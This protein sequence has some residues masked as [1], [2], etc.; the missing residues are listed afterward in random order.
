MKVMTI[1]DHE[2]ELIEAVLSTVPESRVK[3]RQAIAENRSMYDYRTKVDP[4]P[5]KLSSNAKIG[6]KVLNK[7]WKNMPIYTLTLEE[8]ATCPKTC[9]HFADCYGNNMAQ[10]A[11]VLHGKDFEKTLVEQ[12]AALAS[13]HKNGFVVRLHVLGDFYSVDY[14]NLWAEMLQKHSN[15]YIY[16]YTHWHP[17][18]PI[19][20]AIFNLW[21]ANKKRFII[22]FSDYIGAQ[23]VLRAN[24][25]TMVD[26]TQGRMF[27]CPNL[28]SKKGV[29]NGR[30]YPKHIAKDDR[31]NYEFSLS[32]GECTLCWE[33]NKTVIFPT[34]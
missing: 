28:Q 19:G 27:V 25:E 16:G 10:T 1:T 2:L 17:G 23:N 18:T 34:H 13:K 31:D 20:D 21:L 30:N 22:R 7:T 12:L 26:Q 32:C 29:R 15:M 9:G 14:V 5:L 6:R 11:R 3:T 33:T 24:S 8:R 4:K